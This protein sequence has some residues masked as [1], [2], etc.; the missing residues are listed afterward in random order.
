MAKRTKRAKAETNAVRRRRRAAKPCKPGKEKYMR[1]WQS[2]PR[3]GKNYLKCMK[4]QTK[5]KSK[6][7]RVSIADKV[8][9]DQFKRMHPGMDAKMEQMKKAGKTKKEIEK[10]LSTGTQKFIM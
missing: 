2:G 5:R 8:L 10:A 6:S 1:T 3:K 7:P 9:A 4:R